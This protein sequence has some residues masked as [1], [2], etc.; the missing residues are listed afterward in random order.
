MA[1]MVLVVLVFVVSVAVV[2]GL[3]L[4]VT[5]LPGYL[6]QRKLNS[7]LDELAVAPEASPDADEAL[8]KNRHD[9][10]LPGFDKLAAGT[11]RGS[12]LASWIEQSGVAD[13]RQA[14]RPGYNRGD[15]LRVLERQ[16]SAR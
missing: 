6:A 2:M 12:R 4:G 14:S 7:R 5:R 1:P 3:F 11:E 10:V 16:Y 15:F 9:G 8:V 13:R